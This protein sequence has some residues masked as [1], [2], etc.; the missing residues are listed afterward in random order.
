[1]TLLGWSIHRKDAK[2]CPHYPHCLVRSTDF[3]KER[4]RSDMFERLFL[5]ESRK[6]SKL[7]RLGQII[8]TQRQTIRRLK[9]RLPSPRQEGS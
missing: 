4:E 7:N 9:A 6:A 1:M 3:L 8:Y 5:L 2:C